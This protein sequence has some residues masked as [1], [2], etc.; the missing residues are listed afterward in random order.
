MA[1][2]A[3]QLSALEVGRLKAPGMHA[4]GGVAGLYL[5]INDKI[6][7]S[8]IL[9]AT[10]GSK[11]RDMGLG[12]FPDITLAGAYDKAREAR[13]KI[14]LGQDPILIRKQAKSELIAAQATEVTFS[15]AASLYIDAQGDAWKNAK[16]RQQWTNTLEA[17][18]APV[19]GKMLVRDVTHT[20]ISDILEPIRKTKTETATRVRGR[21]ESVLDWATVRG[22]RK[23]EN[24]ARW[25]GH[26]E[27]MLA[28]PGKIAKV[29]HHPA[30]QLDLVNT[31][32]KELRTRN[33]MAARALEFL[34]LTAARSG[35]VRGMLWAEVDFDAGVWTIPAGRMK[36]GKEHRVPLSEAAIRML[37]EHPHFE[38]SELVFPAARGGM[39]SDMTIAAV[40][41]RMD[42]KDKTGRACVPHG[43]RSTFRDWAA[44]RTNYPK[45]LADMALA[46]AVGDKVDAAYRR[47]DM[48]EKRR[49]MMQAWASFCDLPA[50]SGDVVAIK[51]KVAA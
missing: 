15:K 17:Y 1:R 7:R 8:W 49:Q 30:L 23:G 12:G 22:H 6:A 45:D 10:V 38:G 3:K 19:I 39:L 51:R 2:K 9:R 34:I 41:R 18:A 46:H 27:H 31:F 26:L 28:A 47:G 29:E 11:R 33:G 16:H 35:E 5:H 40:T 32:V 14:E 25:K 13:A 44:E 36:M 37:R 4:V 42:Y 20:H 43:F 48:L 21:I 24:P 50:K